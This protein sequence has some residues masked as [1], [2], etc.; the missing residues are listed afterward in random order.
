V[1]GSYR[2]RH[3][4]DPSATWAALGLRRFCRLW[5]TRT[6]A[7][8]ELACAE[9]ERFLLVRYESFTS[10]PADELRRICAFLEEPFVPQALAIERADVERWHPDPDLFGPIVPQT[11]R[12]QD[13]VSQEEAAAIRRE[14]GPLLDRLATCDSRARYGDAAGAA[15][16]RAPQARRRQ[17]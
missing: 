12:W 17:A 3:E 7:A 9:R 16:T 15:A 2:K 8:L 6:E 14:L 5:R 1:L 13:F 11:K 10:D 4:R